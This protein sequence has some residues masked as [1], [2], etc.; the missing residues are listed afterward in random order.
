MSGLAQWLVQRGARVTGSERRA[1]PAV[2]RLRR[3]GIRVDTGPAPRPVWHGAGSLIYGPEVR[4]D[5][6]ERLAAARR[7]IVQVSGLQ[8]L[9]QVIGRGVGLAVLGRHDASVA[10]AMIGWTLTRA[11]LDPTVIL[12]TTAPQL[13]GWARLGQGRH[14]VLEAVE[15]SDE[16]GPLGPSVAVLL[17][18]AARPGTDFSARAE[19]LRRFTAAIPRD[20]HVLAL[21][22][23]DLVAAAL[24]G[25]E[26]PVEGLSL[27]RG[28]AWWGGDLREERGRFRFRAYHRGRFVVEVRLLVPG[29]RSVLSALAAIAACGRLDVPVLDI[30]EGLEE[31]KGVSGDFDS[32]GSYRGVT[33]VDDS[34]RDPA[35]IAAALALA[36]AVYGS[37]RLWAVYHTWAEDLSQEEEARFAAAFAAADQVLVLES[38]PAGGLTAPGGAAGSLARALAG[39]GVRAR[40]MAHL[41]D[42]ISDLDRHLEPGD[43][44]VTLGAGDVGT[45]ADAF[46]RRLSRDRQGR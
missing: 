31:F 14:L 35:A 2:E 28:S 27:E 7:G 29:R 19:A 12:G 9:G 33:L 43:V 4:R 16:F 8:R 23:N 37:R 10:T 6:P 32:R 18:L 41:D 1:G 11:G 15:E 34:G 24:R 21:V 39:A 36:R 17:D 20:G 40:W 38:A 45:I 44:L 13:G 42:A 22:R 25:L 3:L 26:L 30:K 5:H 46:F